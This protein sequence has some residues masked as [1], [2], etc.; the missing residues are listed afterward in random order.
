MKNQGIARRVAFVVAVSV[1]ITVAAVLGLSYLLRTSANSSQTVAAAAREQTQRS[2][3]LLDLAVKIQG[4]TQK[5]VHE[6]DPD[7]MKAL[8]KQAETQIKDAKADLELGA[9]GDPGIQTAF[10]A[11]IKANEHVTK[12]VLHARHA[13]SHQAIVE[14]STPAFEALLGAINTHRNALANELADDATAVRV[15]TDRL[16]ATIFALVVAGILLLVIS[17]FTLVRGISKALNKM[18][19]MMKDLAEGEGDLTKRLEIATNDELSEL[20]GWFNT[21]LIKVH[22]II[23]EVAGTADQVASASEQ[24]SSSATL[25]AQG[26][27]A[28]NDQTTQV[29]TAMQEMSSTVQQVSES[30]TH[31]AEA[32]RHAAETA[33]EGGTVVEKTLTQMRSIAESVG[34]TAKQMVD[35]GRRSDQIGVIA[36]VIDDIADQTN[37]L[38]LNAAIEAARAGEQGRGFAVVADEVRKLAERTTAAT[39]EIAEMIKTIQ[40]GTSGAVKAMEV[41]SQQVEAGVTSTA[42]AGESLQQI[43]HMSEEVG[44]MISHIATAATQQT[45]ASVEI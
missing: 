4:T 30:C 28:Q 23:Y 18:I 39:K 10:D 24:L 38:A 17:G 29:A 26:A 19:G 33:R 25:Q 42:R 36:G 3:E 5:L 21:F 32:S 16:Q 40:D 22:H 37:L 15:R 12:L 31:A 14:K 11:M 34:G 7:A 8:I 27:D 6:T 44:S 20:A 41:G 13:E 1:L 45:G 9:G 43:I 2:F 35:L